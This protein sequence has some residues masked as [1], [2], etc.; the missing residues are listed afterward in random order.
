MA[1]RPKPP[2]QQSRKMIAYNVAMSLAFGAL[3]SLVFMLVL[4]WTL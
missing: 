4:L 1:A 3:V 2:G